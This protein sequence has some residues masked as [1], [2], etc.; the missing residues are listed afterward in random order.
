MK[1]PTYRCCQ[2]GLREDSAR[3]RGL[4]SCSNLQSLWAKLRACFPRDPAPEYFLKRLCPD[5]IFKQLIYN[6]SVIKP[7]GKYNK[8]KVM[9]NKQRAILILCGNR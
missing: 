5:G 8:F 6:F 3:G 1:Q 9:L 2:V 7:M 4:S